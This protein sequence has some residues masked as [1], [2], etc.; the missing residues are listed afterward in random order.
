MTYRDFINAFLYYHPTKLVEDKLCD[1]LKIDPKGSVMKQLTWL[2]IFDQRSIGLKQGS[3]AA[4]LQHLLE[5]KWRLRP[6]DKD[7][8]VMQHQVGY[9]LNGEKRLHITSLVVVGDDNKHTAMSKT[10]G[11]P[12]ALAAKLV[13]TE[14]L[15]EVGVRVPVKATFYKPIIKELGKLGVNISAEDHQFNDSNP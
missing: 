12:L 2:G 4:V 5:Q 9:H 1:Y 3:P 15:N 8:I 11:W 13:L 7:M 6:D 10:V 14:S